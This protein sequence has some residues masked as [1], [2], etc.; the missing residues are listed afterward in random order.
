MVW[1]APVVL[2]GEIL[3]YI[4]KKEMPAN[5]KKQEI[6]TSQETAF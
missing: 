1:D 3:L 4:Q 2:W 6:C 5:C